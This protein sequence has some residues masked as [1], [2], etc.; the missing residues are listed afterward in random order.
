MSLEM[1][2][3]LRNLFILI[4]LNGLM[5]LHLYRNVEV[6]HEEVIDIMAKVSRRIDIVL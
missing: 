4:K 6:T 1:K 2:T 3:Y 5:L